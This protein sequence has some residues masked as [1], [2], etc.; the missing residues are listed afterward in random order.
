M[1]FENFSAEAVKVHLDLEKAG[2]TDDG[3]S[4]DIGPLT[5]NRADRCAAVESLKAHEPPIRQ[6]GLQL[7][8]KIL[9]TFF[10]Y[11]SFVS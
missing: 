9:T 2:V 6:P 8:D 1:P 4:G 3:H 11:R 10:V 7:N 5:A